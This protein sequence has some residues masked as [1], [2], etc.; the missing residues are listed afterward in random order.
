V[1]INP[2][3]LLVTAQRQFQDRQYKACLETCRALLT[4]Q[5]DHP[6]GLLLVARA[7][8]EAG[9]PAMADRAYRMLMSRKPPILAHWLEHAAFLRR[10]GHAAPA[11]DVVREALEFA[12]QAASAWHALGLCLFDQD[13]FAEA[14]EAGTKS[15]K[16][17]AAQPGG[18]ELAAASAQKQGALETAIE[19][20]REGLRHAQASGRLHYALGQLLRQ[21]TAFAEA[22]DAYI[23]AEGAGQTTPEL[24]RNLAEA[25]LDAGRTQDAVTW[26]GRGV[27][28]H[29]AHA[30]LHRTQARIHQVAQACDDPLDGLREAARRESANPLLW[31]TFVDLLKRLGREEEASQA[32]RDARRRGCPDTP[33]ILALEAMDAHYGG[34]SAEA[35][36]RFEALL[37]REPDSIPVKHAFAELAVK[38]KEPG[39]CAELCQAI[40]ARAPHDQLALTYLGTAWQLLG[41][42]RERWLLDYDAMVRPVPVPPPAGY[43]DSGHFFRELRDVLEAL[44]KTT[45]HPLEQSVRGGTQTN[46]FLFRLKETLLQT[47]EQQLRRAI[48]TALRDF[49]EDDEHPFW[50]RRHRNPRGDGLRFAGAW[51]VR[52]RGQ[53]YHTNHVH[54]EGWVSSAL[55][56][57]LPPEVRDPADTSGYIQFGQPMKELGLDLEPRRIVKPEPGTLVLF[58]SYMWH[59]TVPFESDEPR[60]T[61]AFD[62][63]PEG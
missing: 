20:C 57:H 41:D 61:V 52:L 39:R 25:L 47:L 10:Y 55:Y 30:G 54:P 4:G 49:P 18:W 22:A 37:K 8:N 58:P 34:D 38:A 21:E 40:L 13:R 35:M 32:L 15:T 31:Q 60:I 7:A 46:G 28:R 45:A 51:S 6:E 14:Q 23:R 17:D 62:L 27:R 48:V 36:R 1:A 19:T 2:R 11:E 29:P 50:S 12:P 5:P 53:G 59:G 26:V 42:A 9:D 3:Q 56:V 33:G 43:A 24:Y 16:L 44:H 63:L